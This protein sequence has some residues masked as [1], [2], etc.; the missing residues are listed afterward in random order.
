MS[1]RFKIFFGFRIHNCSGLFILA[2]KGQYLNNQCQRFKRK[3]VTSYNST[4]R[5][6]TT[7]QLQVQQRGRRR[8]RY[9]DSPAGP[10]FSKI[11]QGFQK[12][13]NRL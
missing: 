9:S 1:S 10:S 4:K 8:R 11:H 13:G 5:K 6:G 7:M 3:V 12:A 2:I